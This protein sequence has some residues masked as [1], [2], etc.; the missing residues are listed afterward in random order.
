MTKE[1]KTFFTS[2]IKGLENKFD[3]L[4]GKFDKLEGKFD[5]L[6]NRFDGLENRFD[7][8]QNK[9]DGLETQVRHNGVMIEKMQS[10]ISLLVESDQS[11]HQRICRLEEA[12]L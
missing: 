4:E 11:F 2:L 7:G 3:N 6:E 9:F 8:L 12:V 5:N 1:D 10:D